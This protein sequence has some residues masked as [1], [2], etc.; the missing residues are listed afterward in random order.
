M[1]LIGHPQMCELTKG[2][3]HMYKLCTVPYNA[4]LPTYNL[5]VP[6]YNNGP[7]EEW[8]KFCQNL[9]AAITR[10]NITD[11]QGMCVITNSMLCRDVLTAFE[12]AKGV[13]RSQSKLAYK[14][15]MEEVHTHMFLLQA[16]VTQTRYMRWTLMKP[17]NMSLRAFVACVNKMNNCLEQFP[18]RDDRTYQVKLVEDKLMD[19]LENTVPNSWQGEMHRQRFDCMAE[20]QAKFIWFCKCLES[21]DPPKK[22][23][24]GRQD[25]TSATGN[26]Q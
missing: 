16:Y 18:L 3:Y 15:T 4:N 13:N 21:L 12:N 24:K 25:A 8:L 19:I 14:K 5:V 11:P 10:Q 9:Q 7:M 26:Q 1:I 22:D 2:N 23:Q 20:G 6:F 17:H